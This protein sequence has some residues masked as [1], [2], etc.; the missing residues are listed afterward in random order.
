VCSEC[1]TED[2]NCEDT[3]ADKG[4]KNDEQRLMKLN[5]GYWLQEGNYL[6]TF[7]VWC[8]YFLW[9]V[10]SKVMKLIHIITSSAQACSPVQGQ[11]AFRIIHSG[12]YDSAL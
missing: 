3:E 12:K 6:N 8:F 2:G 11:L 9:H 7:H 5:K 4:N 10:N 1:E